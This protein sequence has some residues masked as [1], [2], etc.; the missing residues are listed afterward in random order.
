MTRVLHLFSLW[1]EKVSRKRAVIGETKKTQQ[2]A[3]AESSSRKIKVKQQ[4]AFF[5]V[6]ATQAVLQG[7]T[8]CL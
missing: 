4:S 3:D 5:C 1:H 6:F 2:E 8:L 7:N